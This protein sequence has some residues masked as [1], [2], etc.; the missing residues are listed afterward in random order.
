MRCLLRVG[1]A[2]LLD[3]AVCD[4]DA[5]PVDPAVEPEAQDRLE[6]G[7]HLRVL[8][9][10]VGLLG[11]EEV[12]VPLTGLAVGLGD[13]RPRSAAEDRLPVVGRQLATLAATFAEEVAL[14]LGRSGASREGGL[15]PVVLVGRVVGH[16]VDDDL[17]T[18][19]V[20]ALDHGVGVRERAEEGVDVPVVGDVVAGVGLGRGVERREPRA[21]TPRSRRW[22]R[23]EVMP[24]RSPMP[25]PS[26]SAHDR[27]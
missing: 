24:G 13:T 21:S 20:R 8:P 4:V 18:E 6:L 7:A 19:L 14:P 26:L 3:E 23:R 11:V 12:Q 25:S 10:E 5:E 2:L 9:V 27:G 22:C 17:E 1:Q 15:E 16:H